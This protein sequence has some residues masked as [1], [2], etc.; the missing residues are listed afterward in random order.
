ML[1]CAYLVLSASLLHPDVVNKQVILYAV[2]SKC[3]PAPLE[4]NC[5]GYDLDL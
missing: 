5:C 3:M 2:P 4:V 1:L